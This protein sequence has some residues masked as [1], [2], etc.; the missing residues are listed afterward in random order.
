MASVVRL[1]S[2][3]LARALRNGVH[4]AVALAQLPTD[5]LAAV[6]KT[7][8]VLAQELSPEEWVRLYVD[9]ANEIKQ[10]IENLEP[11]PTNPSP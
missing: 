6:R 5:K 8:T 7:F 9:Y 11:A 2:Q 10:G 3:E 1:A 4:R